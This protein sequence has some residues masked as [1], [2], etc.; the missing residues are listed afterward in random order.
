MSPRI[1]NLLMTTTALLALGP[2]PGVA[3][4]DGA[5]VVNGAANV[6]G[7]G[8]DKVVVNQMTDKAVI[9][10]NTFNIG[11]NEAAQFNQPNA[12]S[13]ILNRVTGGLG[14]SLIDGTLTA[15]GRVFLIN[16]D[17]MLFGR[18]SVINTAGFLATTSDIKNSDFMAGRYNFD[19]PGRPD[20]SIVNR[21]RITATD[22]GFAALVAPGVRNTG[23]ITANLGTVSLAAGNMYTLDLYGDRLIQLAVNDQIAAQVKDVATGQPL[24]ALVS[25]K[26]KLAANGGRVELTAAAA[27]VVVDSVINNKGVIEANSVGLRNGMIVIGAA[28]G[29]SKPAGLPKQT[30]KISGTLSA[31]GKTQDTK[32]GTIVVTGE[33]I[34]LVGAQIDASGSA[35][36]GKVMIGGDW[37]G[38]HPNLA[39]VNNQAA[40]LETYTIA[41]ATTLSVDAATTINASATDRGNGGKVVLWSDN[42]TTFAGTIFALGGPNAWANGGGLTGSGVAGFGAPGDSNGGFVEVSSHGQLNYLGTAD[43]RAPNGKTGTLLLDPENYYVN[44]TGIAPGGDPTASAISATALSTQLGS[45]NVVIST[46]TTGPNAGDIFVN[47]QVSWSSSNT[48]TLSA[49]RNVTIDGVGSP[50]GTILNTGAGN[51]IVRADN[52]GIGTGTIFL[53]PST[54]LNRVNWVSSTGTVSFYYNPANYS[55]PTNFTTANGQVTT[56]SPGQF[57]A[58]MLVNSVTDLQNMHAN[59]TTLGGTYALGRNFSASSFVPGGP[60]TTFTGLF[61]GNGGLGVNY[62]ISDLT[63]SAPSPGPIG[64]FGFIDTGAVVRNLNLANVNITATGNTVFVAPLAG[65][66]RGTIDNVHVLSGTVGVSST[67]LT[68][69]LA[70]GL[71]GQNKGAITNSVSAANVTVRNGG[72]GGTN[73]AGGLVGINV[74]SIASSSAS[75]TILG[76]FNSS[77][78]GLAG[79][80]GGGPGANSITSSF[81]TGNVTGNGGVGG[82]VGFATAN[83]TITGSHASGNVIANAVVGGTNASGGGLVGQNQGLIETSFYNTGTVSGT[84]TG[85]LNVPG[86]LSVSLGGLVGANFNG[87]TV[88]DSNATAIVTGT[89]G[90]FGGLVGNNF[91]TITGTSPGQV[92]ANATVTVG[93]AHSSGGAL[94]GTNGNGGTIFN[95]NATGTVAPANATVLSKLGGLVGQNDG[96]VDHSTANV[97]VTG[98]V[99]SAGGLVG[100]NDGSITSSSASG[101]VTG[102]G[103]LTGF[104]AIGG[105]VGSNNSNGEI[106]NSS[107]SGTVTAGQFTQAGGLVG[108][109]Q[110]SIDSSF[111]T[112]NVSSTALNVT[113]GGLVGFNTSGATITDSRA[114]G[115]VTATANVPAQQQGPD[116][117]VTGNCQFVEVGGLVGLNFGTIQ[118]TA[119]PAANQACVAGQTCATGAVSVGSNAVGGGLVGWNDGIIIS[120]FATG[121]VT[122][123]A[124]ISNLNGDGNPTILGGLA[125]RNTGAIADSHARGNVG[126]LN[127]ANL[128][129]G[130][131]VGENAGAILQSFATGQVRAGDNSQA[132]GLVGANTPFDNNNCNACMPGDGHNNLAVIIDSHASGGVTVGTGSLAGGLVGANDGVIAGTGPGLS[133]ATGAVS[134]GGNSFLG[135]LAGVSGFG[136]GNFSAI[137]L[138]SASGSVTSSG[139]NSA[140]GGLV[141]ANASV[142]TNSTSSGPVTGTSESFLGGLAGINLGAIIDST[143]SGSVNAPGANNVIGGFVGLNLGLIDPS[144]STGNVSGG[145][146]SIIGSFVGAN[147]T[148]GNFPDGLL[149]VST[150]P[151]GTI[152]PDSNGTGTV[153]GGTGPQVGANQPTG[154]LPDY[155][156]IIQGCDAG[157]CEAL[158]TGT[159]KGN[160]NQQQLLL[161]LDL[162]SQ[163]LNIQYNTNQNTPAG[164][165]SEVVNTQ[166]VTQPQ[167]PQQQ[168]QQ[169][170][171]ADINT[172]IRLNV[173][174]GRF[175]YLPPPGETRLIVDEA[176]LQMPCDVN[177]QARDAAMTQIRLVVISSQCLG[178]SNVAVY[179]VRMG[180]G[181]TLASTL[182][183]LA[184]RRFVVAAQANYVYAL[185]QDPAARTSGDVQGDAGQYVIQKLQLAETH[186]IAKGTNISI[187]VI[188]SEI[189]GTHPDLDGGI[190]SRFDATGSEERPHAHGTGMAGAIASHRRLVGIAP[191][192]QLFAIRAFSSKAASAESTTFNILKGLDWASTNG[193]RIIN[194]SFAGPRDPSFERALKAAYDKGLILIAAAGNAG[195]K[196]PPL[197]P[198]AHPNVIAVTATDM[199]DKLFAGANRG[200]H[201][202]VAAPGVDIL[203]PAPEGTY[204]VT[205]GTSVA[206]AHI[207]GI[208]A[209]LLERN[210]AL[211]PADVRRIL[212][213]SAKKLGPND[214]FG[215]GLV[216]PIKALQLGAP[217]SAALTAPVRR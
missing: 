55:T 178:S 209:L 201:I 16:R 148:Y 127:V 82:L 83:S 117:A 212:T 112:G 107:A 9:N 38:G 87:A 24:T 177:Q 31:A 26:G 18:N 185:A 124:G 214:Q 37:A 181:Q 143:S 81:A 50:S 199:D 92:F 192:A 162:P 207:S 157:A 29:A 116:C 48:L 3:G 95:A 84:G 176:V 140:I 2:L 15:N 36:G 160:D 149:P 98:G 154:G 194:M 40:R 186:R 173:G 101:N 193:V 137:I 57:K 213:A 152:S 96:S 90:N 119:V 94:V 125:G 59:A 77:V 172:P 170:R 7:Q 129:V 52:T 122:G 66:N 45:N 67:S 187:A 64:L 75:G 104:A 43:T 166:G 190:A 53:N 19:S 123:A 175:F 85:A 147:A 4:P 168:N 17:G 120:A 46:L 165:P 61:D 114:T 150:F 141:G 167:Q 216:D 78:G 100:Q 69:V 76:G 211:T 188:D 135:G 184:A 91:G 62:T 195:P 8:T 106:S 182:Q 99:G 169:Q 47:A 23:T 11:A 105:L 103:I 146:N 80:N 205:T 180:A 102:T 35:G 171:I 131:L 70:G 139:P 79:Q 20:A 155:P 191:A 121:G 174:E 68:G 203:V 110:A 133:Y 74:G 10:W 200:R 156:S 41:T 111:A 206:A 34:K 6:Q 151:T 21:G 210:A 113:L 130:G 27:R 49:F 179:R 42:Q 13:V 217:K 145:P 118:G 202:A 196:S 86:T 54:F 58:Y 93:G 39:L 197:Y 14:P 51:L 12:N 132:G 189:D 161:P 208:V 32:G 183:A 153:N 138:S 1:R 88:R 65:E 136:D 128:E 164:P 144:F 44:A 158:R 108:L 134:G 73:V 63:I 28:T 33:D 163:L 109:N 60:G 159:F 215:A 115:N 97:T 30:V 142:I 71:V 72:V 56:A 198:A 126:T 25:N 5:V 204:Q 22:G 89:F